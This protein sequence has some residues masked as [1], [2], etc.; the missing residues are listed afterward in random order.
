MKME[1]KEEYSDAMAM[2]GSYNSYGSYDGG[3]YKYPYDTE[4][5]LKGGSFAG[6]RGRNANRDS[7]GRYSSEAGYSRDEELT[8]KIR[9]IINAAPDERTRRQ[10]EEL[11]AEM[12]N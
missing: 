1:E 3:S 6:G 11:L 2:R 7:M 8:G 4:R 10:L 5:Y 9:Q 12:G